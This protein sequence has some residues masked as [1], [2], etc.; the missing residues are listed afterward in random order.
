[1][2]FRFDRFSINFVVSFRPSSPFSVTGAAL[3]TPTLYLAG[4]HRTI[5]LMIVGK[6]NTLV[7]QMKQSFRTSAL[8]LLPLFVFLGLNSKQL[9][10]AWTIRK[11]TQRLTQL[12]AQ[13]PEEFQNPEAM[14]DDFD[15]ELS[16]HFWEFFIINGG[17]QVSQARAWHSAALSVEEG[18]N[19]QHFPDP[20]F[21]HENA[22][23]MQKPAAGQYNNVTLIGG[24]GFQPTPSS[25]VVL[26]FSARVSNEFYGTA[27]VIFQ[28]VGTLQ[29]DGLFVKPFDMFGFSAAGEESSIQG[30][31][32]ALCYLALNWI[33]VEVEALPVEAHGWHDYEIR[34]HWF[35]RTEWTGS[36]SVDGTERCRISMPAFGPVEVQVWSDNAWVIHKPQRWWELASAMELKFQDGGEKQFY[37]ENI[38]VFE[39]A[40]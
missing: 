32:G 2:L 38:Q 1:M 6:S 40:R 16:P 3:A 8:F 31:N 5:H 35:S 36:L 13:A 23:F 37:L 19:L 10:S 30:A 25:D 17:G 11:E 9:V 26:R 7:W 29:E 33:P 12:A 20:E 18:L 15:G 28:P 27:G 22:N 34:L 39:E 4:Y 24:R 21:R 14:G